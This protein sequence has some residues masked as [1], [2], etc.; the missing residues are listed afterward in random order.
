MIFFLRFVVLLLWSSHFY[1]L[2]ISPVRANL[3]LQE[4]ITAVTV[5]NDTGEPLVLQLHLVK[6]FQPN[7]HNL[8][9]ATDDLMVTPPIFTLKPYASQ[10]IRIGLDEAQAQP[11]EQA[12][13]L[14]IEEVRSTFR[15]KQHGIQFV[16]NISI[17]VIL[18]ATAPLKEDIRW[19]VIRSKKSTQLRAKNNGN[20]VVFIS[21]IALLNSASRNSVKPFNT[22]TY[23]LPGSTALWPLPSLSSSVKPYRIEALVNNHTVTADAL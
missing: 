2:S 9:V 3:S 4:P 6:W 10:L 12:Y 13:R 23:L 15:S 18:G 21:R 22:F 1:A 8:E 7:Q 16:L 20:N 19:T 11:V 5:T 17:P 14:K